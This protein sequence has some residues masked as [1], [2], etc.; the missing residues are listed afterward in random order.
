MQSGIKHIDCNEYSHYSDDKWIDY[1]L[2]SNH[3]DDVG[4]YNKWQYKALSEYSSIATFAKFSLQL[5]S[6]GAPL[7]FIQLSN[8]AGLDEIRH[9]QISMDIANMY[10]KNEYNDDNECVTFGVFPEHV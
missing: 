8:E 5:M 4:M 6:I 1:V 7:W 10:V 9:S 3:S 2:S